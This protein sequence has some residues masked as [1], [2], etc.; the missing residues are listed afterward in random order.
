[1]L[2]EKQDRV[3]ASCMSYC[4]IAT[5]KYDDQ[6]NLQKEAFNWSVWFQRI[7]GTTKAWLAGIARPELTSWCAGRKQGTHWECH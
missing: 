3:T 6:G 5:T 2:Q 4:S 1:M 7:N